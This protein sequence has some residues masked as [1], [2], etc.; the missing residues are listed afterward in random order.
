M[1][2]IFLDTNVILDLLA[3][4]IPFFDSIAKVATLADQKKLILV[5]SPLSFTTVEYILNK[6]ESSES[7]LSKLRKFKII[8]EVC[9]VNEETIEKGLNSS[10]K[11]FEDAVQYFTAIQSS[12]SIIITRNGKDFKSST[13]P[14]M[15]AEEYLSSIL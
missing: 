3:E 12:C 9:E 6:F 5:V 11:D 7:V 8:C 10:F 14:I 4:R 13:I 1:T 15:T 2:R